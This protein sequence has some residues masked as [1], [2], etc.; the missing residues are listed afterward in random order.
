MK[1]II[2]LALMVTVSMLLAQRRLPSAFYNNVGHLVWL[3]TS[4]K[5]AESADAALP[6]LERA[7]VFD[8]SYMQ[9][10]IRAALLHLRNGN[11]E[12]AFI[13]WKDGRVDPVVL[14]AYGNKEKDGGDFSTALA[15]F[16]DAAK[17]GA[18]EGYLRAGQICQ[19][20]FNRPERLNA[21]ERR[22]CKAFFEHNGNSLILNGDFNSGGLFGW[23]QRYWSGFS[24]TYSIERDGNRQ[25]FAALIQGNSDNEVGAISQTLTVKAGTMVRFSARVKADLERGAQL[26]LLHAVWTRPDG[27]SGGNQLATL[28]ED[29]EWRFVER[30]MSLQPAENDAYTFSP[31]IL[32]GK[33]KVWIDDV[34]LETLSTDQMK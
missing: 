13:H 6:Y 2:V 5:Q 1:R 19:Q 27:K 21:D 8:P 16:R 10:H 12:E 22:F 24:G 33:G 9:A 15:L 28:D 17:L 23:G 29:L 31:A 20:E 26:R 25:S 3:R 7:L 4:D 34:H 14:V 30:I 18:E 32:T 11:E